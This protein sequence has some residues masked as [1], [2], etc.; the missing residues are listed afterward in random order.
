MSAEERFQVIIT[1]MS[2]LFLLLTTVLGLI[3]RNGNKQGETNA[4]I[5]GMAED[6]KEIA[7]SLDSHIKWHM[8]RDDGRRR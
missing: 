3:W 6:I 8:G 5:E 2:F 7:G 4:K 1:G